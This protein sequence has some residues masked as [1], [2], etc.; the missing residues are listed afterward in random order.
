ME[1]TAE[2]NELFSTYVVFLIWQKYFAISFPTQFFLFLRRGK[3]LQYLKL[4]KH[5]TLNVTK[6]KK[7]I[8]SKTII[9]SSFE[10]E[11]M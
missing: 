10:N 1:R 4:E 5:K 2:E 7:I 3:L 11:G 8:F 6:Q 9:R